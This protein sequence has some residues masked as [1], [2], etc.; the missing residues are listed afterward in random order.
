MSVRFEP[1]SGRGAA[2]IGQHRRAFDTSAWRALISGMTRPKRRKRSA[3]L[4][5][6]FFVEVQLAP[7]QFRDGL[8]RAVVVGRPKP[9]GGD[10]H[11]GAVERV[12]ERRAH[13]VGRVA[14]DG[15]VDHANAQLIQLGGKKKG[16]GIQA[17][18][19]SAVRSQLR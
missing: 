7:E 6:H 14:D 5:K 8:A 12:P 9:A 18:T 4:A 10:D 16:I 2:R 3:D 17:V 15:L 19:A 13:F 1:Q 11:V